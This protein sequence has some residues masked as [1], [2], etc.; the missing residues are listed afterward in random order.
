LGVWIK[1]SR[2]QGRRYQNDSIDQLKHLA[3]V[4]QTILH[5]YDIK[6][7]GD[8]KRLDDTK[9][10]EIIRCTKLSA[11]RM[12]VWRETAA[13]CVDEDAP[14]RTDHRKAKNPYISKYGEDNW[15]E[16]C[17]KSVMLSSYACITELVR[18]M[19]DE[20]QKVMKG[21]K[22]E[23]GE[24]YFYHDALSLMTAKDTIEWMKAQGIYKRWL[25]PVNGL[26]EDD[27][28][29]K[30]FVGRPVGNSPEMM[31]LDCSLNQDIH[32]AVSRHVV[33][34]A[35][36][37]EENDKKFST[38]TPLRGTSAYLRLWD[39]VSGTAPSSERIVQD[40]RK[41]LTAMVAI[42]AANGAIVPGL[43]NRKGKRDGGTTGD[44]VVR[45]GYHP[46]NVKTD[47]HCDGFA[48]HEDA[49]EA[50]T[51]KIEDAKQKNAA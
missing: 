37:P 15:K 5:C 41:V 12:Q 30:N 50:W 2:V 16:R 26:S 22:H 35:D 17:A 6:T 34:T 32:V 11:G 28:E 13:T 24:W 10:S 36:L 42:R 8:L 44:D 27:P 4:S 31:P 51:G 25:L 18:H 47:K 45:G 9:A 21:T 38:S 33:I 23:H 46:R 19:H 49:R 29:L 40:C 48:V 1:D 7:L 39:P 43:G 3:K 20:T 14:P